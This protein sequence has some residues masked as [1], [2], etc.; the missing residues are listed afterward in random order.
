[1]RKK[2]E[3]TKTPPTKWVLKEG[4]CVDTTTFTNGVRDISFDD[5]FDLHYK[6]DKK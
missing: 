2:Q 5:W 4:G 1:M 3:T 6:N